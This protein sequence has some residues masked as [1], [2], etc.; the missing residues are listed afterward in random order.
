M[1]PVWRTDVGTWKLGD[2]LLVQIRRHRVCWSF[3]DG[4]GE[5]EKP[6]STV[7]CRIMTSR[8][9]L[10]LDRCQRPQSSSNVSATDAWEAAGHRMEL[11]QVPHR[12]AWADRRA[13]QPRRAVRS[14]R[15]CRKSFAVADV[16]KGSKLR[17]K[18]K[19]LNPN[20]NFSKENIFRFLSASLSPTQELQGLHSYS[21]RQSHFYF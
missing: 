8:L 12:Q 5:K 10:Y 15:G 4:N 2:L 21:A 17:I 16:E 18:G 6:V 1:Q 3:L 19:L 11:H 20:L 9:H 7:Q 13:L 14:H